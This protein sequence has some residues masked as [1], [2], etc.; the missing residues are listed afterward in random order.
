MF[1]LGDNLNPY[2]VYLRSEHVCI[3]WPI[4]FVQFLY[5][6]FQRFSP[7]AFKQSDED[8][9]TN[10]LPMVHSVQNMQLWQHL[11]TEIDHLYIQK[12]NQVTTSLEVFDVQFEVQFMF[13]KLSLPD[14]YIQNSIP[15]S[16]P[17]SAILNCKLLLQVV[18]DFICKEI[19]S[20][21]SYNHDIPLQTFCSYQKFGS[22]VDLDL[23]GCNSH[24]WLLVLIRKFWRFGQPLYCDLK[25]TN[26]VQNN[27]QISID[28]W[29]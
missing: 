1:Y 22:N 20:Q 8:W 23:S 17:D 26:F 2:P 21:P 7:Q 12:E 10:F 6:T 16:A 4:I 3:L 5:I 27:F 29:F 24:M 18:M 25:I 19:V 11:I 13:N 15:S 9:Y 14:I 28:L